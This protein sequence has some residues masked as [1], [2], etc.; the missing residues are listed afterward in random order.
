MSDQVRYFEV[1][2]GPFDPCPPIGYKSY[3]VPPN[4]FITFQPPNWPQFQPY[5][6]LKLGT[7]WQP[8]YSPYGKQGSQ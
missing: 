7:L 5:D 4:L 1:F 6:A 3:V 8:L 2:A